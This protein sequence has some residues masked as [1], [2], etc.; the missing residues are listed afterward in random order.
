MS[1]ELGPE[2]RETAALSAERA[3]L[4]REIEELEISKGE[5]KKLELARKKLSDIELILRNLGHSP[6]LVPSRE[7]IGDE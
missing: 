2:R 3:E 7:E 1:I 6:D 5:P 4:L